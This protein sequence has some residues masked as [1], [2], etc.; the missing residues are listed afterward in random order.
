MTDLFDLRYPIGRFVPPGNY[1]A[2][3][4]ATQLETL[5]LLPGHLR[6]AVNGLSDI[7]LD[8]SYRPEG[9][10]VRQV[11][12]HVADSHANSYVRF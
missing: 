11:V 4:R 5:R 3:T 6:A 7:Q 1:T 12:H 9:W 2:G 10:T 8:T